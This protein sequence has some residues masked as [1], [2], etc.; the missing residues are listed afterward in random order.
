MS[1]RPLARL[2]AKTTPLAIWNRVPRRL[3]WIAC[4][5]LLL[6]IYLA[7]F[8]ASEI[9]ADMMLQTVMRMHWSRAV[10]ISPILADILHMLIVLPAISFLVPSHQ[11]FVVFGFAAMVG[12]ATLVA[13]ST[14]LTGDYLAAQPVWPSSYRLEDWYWRPFRDVMN[15]I[16][17]L[18][19][20]VW[21]GVRL[22]RHQP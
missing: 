19:I 7:G 20:V 11:H 17:V 8:L 21:Y 13:L 22:Q 6:C 15:C 16:V 10:A 14:L 4:W 3:R 5:P 9:M 2:L 12:I 1:I 18:A